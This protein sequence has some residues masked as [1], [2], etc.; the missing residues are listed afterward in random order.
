MPRQYAT[1]GKTRLLGRISKQGNSYLRSL[2]IHGVRTLVR[3]AARRTDALRCWIARL[4]Q[5]KPTN[6]VTVALADKL[7]RAA[8]VVL[9]RQETFRAAALVN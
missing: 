1:G 4:Q 5:R 3:H 6:V 2:L 7:A 8:C 9:H